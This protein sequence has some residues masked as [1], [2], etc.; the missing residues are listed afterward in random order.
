MT[1]DDFPTREQMAAVESLALEWGSV[2]VAPKADERTIEV[3]SPGQARLVIDENGTPHRPEVRGGAFVTLQMPLLRELV[4]DD[5]FDAALA[6]VRRIYPDTADNP[7]H[8]GY[9]LQSHVEAR[10]RELLAMQA[11]RA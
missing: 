1:A 6:T 8:I 11:V 7:W 10:I 9:A 2:T 5:T 4:G 3:T